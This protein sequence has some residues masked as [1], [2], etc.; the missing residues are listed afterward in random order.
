M[1]RS[2]QELSIDMVVDTDIFESNQIT[3]FPCTPL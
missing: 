2:R 1:E 3:L